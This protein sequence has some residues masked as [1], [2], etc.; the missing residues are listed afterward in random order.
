MYSGVA[1][2]SI[3]N[4]WCKR[5]IHDRGFNRIDADLKSAENRVGQGF[6]RFSRSRGD[7]D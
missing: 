4:L 6:S 5:K 3:A 1:P 2:W 7:R